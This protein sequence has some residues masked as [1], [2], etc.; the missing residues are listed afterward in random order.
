MADDDYKKLTFYC[1]V[2]EIPM[3]FPYKN[4]FE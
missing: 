2:D 1:F 3:Q 4:M